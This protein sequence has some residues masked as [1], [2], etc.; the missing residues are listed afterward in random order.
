LPR[1]EA[2][3]PDEYIAKLPPARREAIAA[4]RDV[5]RKNLPPGFEAARGSSRATRAGKAG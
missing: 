4:V 5:I 2:S 3:T 1:L